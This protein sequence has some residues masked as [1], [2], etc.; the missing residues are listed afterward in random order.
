MIALAARP[1]ERKG[2]RRGYRNGRKTRTVTGPTGPLPLTLPRATIFRPGGAHEWQST[3]VPRYAAP[4]QGSE[5]RCRRDLPRGNE[6]A[7]DPWGL[8]AAPQ[9]RPALQERRVAG[10]G[11]VAREPADL[12][13]PVAGGRRRDRPLPGRDRLARPQRRPRR[14]LAS[15]GRRRRPAR[16]PQTTPGARMLRRGI[17]RGLARVCRGPGRARAGRAP[18]LHHRRQSRAAAGS[19]GDLAHRPRAALLRALSRGAG[20]AERRPPWA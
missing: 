17:G 19:R 18:A 12:D 5:R 11:D 16:R 6:H 2:G 20:Y 9:R 7:A 4:G 13:D 14:Q 1:Y 3:I 10:G 8:G 15:A